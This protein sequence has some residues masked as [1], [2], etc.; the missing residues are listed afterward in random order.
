MNADRM[1]GISIGVQAKSMEKLSSG[2]KINRAADDAAGLSISE[3]MRRQIRGLSQ[4]TKNAQDGISMVQIA[5][6]AL[7]E[8]HD[9]LQRGNELMIKAANGTLSESDREDIQKE[10]RQL[11]EAIDQIAANTKFNELRLFPAD[12][13]DPALAGSATINRYE[14]SFDENG[15]SGI[16]HTQQGEGVGSSSAINTGNALADK[17]AGEYVPNAINQILNKFGSLKDIIDAT[18][19]GDAAD[20]LKMDLG[21]K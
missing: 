13:A 14:L 17:I 2:Y 5:D 16:I 15:V 9:M 20:K 8:V 3:K 21:I 12:G 4:A 18:Y 6:G 19:T 1:Y 7:T 10:I 11:N